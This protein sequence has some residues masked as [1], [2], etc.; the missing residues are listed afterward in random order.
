MLVNIHDQRVSIERRGHLAQRNFF[1]AWI[2]VAADI[3]ISV[4]LQV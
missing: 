1:A 2:R 3:D 4:P